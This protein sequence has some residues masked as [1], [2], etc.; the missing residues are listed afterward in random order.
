MKMAYTVKVVFKQEELSDKEKSDRINQFKQAFVAA[1][2][3]YY[4][5]RKK[6]N[7]STLLDAK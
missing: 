1:A 4:K 7:E 5:S 3:D 6:E 2:V